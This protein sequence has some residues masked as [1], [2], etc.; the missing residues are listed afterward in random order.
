MTKEELQRSLQ[1]IANSMDSKEIQE[2]RVVINKFFMNKSLQDSDL[3]K[4][5][6][7]LVDKR[8][9][10]VEENLDNPAMSAKLNHIST[11]IDR[12]RLV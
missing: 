2:H 9:S 1:I 7:K 4:D 6:N 5:W 8:I 3:E 12:L 10:D 11:I